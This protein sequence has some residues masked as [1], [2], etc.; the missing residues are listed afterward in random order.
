MIYYQNP[1]NKKFYLFI[2]FRNVL[3]FFILYLFFTINITPNRYPRLV[4][5][6]QI[7]LGGFLTRMDFDRGWILNVSPTIY[8]KQLLEE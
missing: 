1:P 8:T 7:W 6:S 5:G 2:Y 3:N 4:S